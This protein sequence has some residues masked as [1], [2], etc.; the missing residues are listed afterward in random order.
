[1][2]SPKLSIEF[3][4]EAQIYG[5]LMEAAK[6][7]GIYADDSFLENFNNTYDAPVLTIPANQRF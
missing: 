4:K 6:N 5:A 7:A 3:P 1:M 2:I